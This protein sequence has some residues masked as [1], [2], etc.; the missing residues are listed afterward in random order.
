M[1]MG[2]IAAKA[3]F[4]VAL[5]GLLAAGEM[6]PGSWV[7]LGVAGLALFIVFWVITKTLP[8]V[9]SQIMKGHAEANQGVVA[10]LDELKAEIAAGRDDQLNLLRAA[11]ADKK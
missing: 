9:I 6:E 3:A 8:D 11:I 7:Q 1:I 5:A 4:P 10:K 2:T